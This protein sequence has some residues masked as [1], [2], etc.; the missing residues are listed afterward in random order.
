MD[1]YFRR[2][3]INAESGQ[4]VVLRFLVQGRLN[5]SEPRVSN[6]GNEIAVVLPN[7]EEGKKR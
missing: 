3:S 7:T 5:Y 4:Q 6:S 2:I 1:C